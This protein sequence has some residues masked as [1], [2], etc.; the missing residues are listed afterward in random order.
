MPRRRQ[1]VPSVPDA[2]KALAAINS[3]AR[4]IQFTYRQKAR[5]IVTP[6]MPIFRHDVVA[7]AIYRSIA[8]PTSFAFVREVLTSLP[9]PAADEPTRRMLDR[10]EEILR[11]IEVDRAALSSV[12]V[13]FPRLQLFKRAVSLSATTVTDASRI[14]DKSRL[15]KLMADHAYKLRR[16]IELEPSKYV[17]TYG[18]ARKLSMQTWLDKFVQPALSQLT[19]LHPSSFGFI[20]DFTVAGSLNEFLGAFF[21][22][23]GRKREVR[24]Q[25]RAILTGIGGRWKVGPQGIVQEIK[26]GRVRAAPRRVLEQ[27]A[28]QIFVK[29]LIPELQTLWRETVKD[30]FLKEPTSV[31]RW[32]PN[33][34]MARKGLRQQ[35]SLLGMLLS[36]RVRFIQH[37]SRDGVVGQF[38]NFRTELAPYW[39]VVQ[40]GYPG[41]ISAKRGRALTLKDPDPEWWQRVEWAFG[42]TRKSR[43]MPFQTQ[44]VLHPMQPRRIKGLGQVITQREH[45][46]ARIPL[47]MPSGMRF[48]M[49]FHPSLFL[50]GKTK[51]VY[52][53]ESSQGKIRRKLVTYH[54]TILPT[55]IMR[56]E[57]RGQ[58]ASLF[59]ERIL[60]MMAERQK[61]LQK[62]FFNAATA[63]LTVGSQTWNE[64]VAP[65]AGAGIFKVTSTPR[66]GG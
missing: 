28:H 44:T 58:R 39:P 43:A 22:A 35:Q 20:V 30:F 49:S 54:L 63:Y 41:K 7:P 12:K 13:M 48:G 40:W 15:V 53:E 2:I 23:L 25:V 56:K 60:A 66:L 17:L 34:P 51:P 45:R 33:R 24:E 37:A 59:I 62:A 11:V 16:A 52:F 8:G 55:A 42:V 50:P 36:G 47:I 38:W 31:S 19:D 65:Q 21:S 18:R 6:M 4:S 5:Q 27:A 57:V 32:F 3:A 61:I 26:G 29:I 10:L 1:S 14:F 9:T 46:S 64:L